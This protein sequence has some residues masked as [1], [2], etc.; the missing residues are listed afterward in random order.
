[1]DSVAVLPLIK[2]KASTF[3]HRRMMLLGWDED[4]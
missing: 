3:A 4:Q 2:P 1:M